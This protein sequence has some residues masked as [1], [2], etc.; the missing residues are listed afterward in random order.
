MTKVQA[1][2]QVFSVDD[3]ED[4]PTAFSR[5]LEAAKIKPGY[6]TC[7]CRQ[8]YQQLVVRRVASKDGDRFFLATWPNTGTSHALECRFHHSE[9][10][11]EEG[12]AKRLA[13]VITSDDG[14]TIK[15]DFTLVRMTSIATQAKKT[16]GD[17]V[18]TANGTQRS[19]LGLLGTL[20]FLWE[21][22]GL[23]KWLASYP[24]AAP[25]RWTNLVTRVNSVLAQGK[26]GGRRLTDLFYVVPAY[27]PIDQDAINARLAA[28]IDAHKPSPI[29]VPSFLVLGEVAQ[30]RE[31]GKA[32]QV[33]LRHQ[34]QPL[35][36]FPSLG[37][38]IGKRYRSAESLLVSQSRDGRVIG[39]FAVE[40]T[41]KGGLW[42]K[43]AAL[44]ACSREYIPCDSRHEIHL[45]NLL[46]HQSRSFVKPLRMEDD[47]DV[48][49][50]FKLFD[51]GRTTVMEV[52][53]MDTPEYNAHRALKIDRYK[54][55][56]VPLWQWDAFKDVPPPPLPVI[57]N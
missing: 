37:E 53:G 40:V 23:N 1:A 19:T 30:V 35:W 14:F 17:A 55:A 32:V 45:A 41:S 33:K 57:S 20:E 56:G 18:P 8:P 16:L 24:R 5:V 28:M 11:Y 49:P 44:M 46:T 3:Y 12:R 42:V 34:A 38:Q 21:T 51:C 2:G 27:N 47:A 29:A 31:A 9:D 4:N 13:A 6:A 36:M 10:E 52:W 43:D 25:Q 15:P 22:A 7:L 54:Q 26:M 39:L 50:D 48:L